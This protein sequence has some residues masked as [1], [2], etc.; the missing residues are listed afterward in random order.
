MCK[1]KVIR[2]IKGQSIISA[3]PRLS[4]SACMIP[5]ILHSLLVENVCSFTKLMVFQNGEWC[6][7]KDLDEISDSLSNNE[8]PDF[9]KRLPRSLLELE[10]YKA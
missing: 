8:P 3:L 1:D 9:F 2:G 4:K 6:I 10:N 5:E 7:K